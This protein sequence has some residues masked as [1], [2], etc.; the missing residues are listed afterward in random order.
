MM[1]S[2]KFL[3]AAPLALI[4]GLAFASPAAAQRWDGAGELRSDIRDLD[5]TV[6]RSAESRRYTNQELRQL[7]TWIG[8]L[9]E[10]YDRYARGGWTRTEVN[11][12][13]E[14]IDSVRQRIRNAGDNDRRGRRR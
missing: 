4:A 11:D 8:N 9:E 14:R 1:I 10:R 7:R 13:G 3:V 5:R 6:E 2:K 12:L